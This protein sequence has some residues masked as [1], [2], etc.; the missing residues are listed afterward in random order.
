MLSQPGALDGLGSKLRMVMLL[1]WPAIMA[2]MSNIVM[3]YIDA[4]MVGS[5]GATQS[6]AIGLVATSTWLVW[7]LAAA[8]CTGF[9]VQV[10]HR[11]G[12][13]DD[14]GARSVTRSAI[15][16][17]FLVGLVIAALSVAIAP[18]LPGWL[19]GK[20]DIAGPA[21]W[22]FGIFAAGVPLMGLTFL[23]TALLRSSG[24]MT[25]PGLTN[26]VM[27]L[28]DVVFNFFLIFPTR[29]V[30]VFGADITIPGA[31][32]GVPGAALGTL[33]AYS[34]GGVWMMSYIFNRSTHISHPWQGIKGQARW[35]LRREIPVRAAVIGWPVAL[36]RV[37]MTGAQIF[38][39]T[40]V[41]PLGNAAIAANAFAVTAE[42]LCY[43]PGYGVG[44]AATTLVGQ[45]LGA[46]RK[47]LARGFARIS[48]IS[49]MIIMGVLGLVMWLLAPQ[50]MSLFSSDQEIVSLGSM[51]LRTEAWAEPMFAAAIV[52]YGVFVGAGY[53]VVP[54]CINFG[55]IWLVRITLAWI[56]AP[57]MGLYGIWL[58]MCIELCVR[59][60]VFLICLVGKRWLRKSRAVPAEAPALDASPA[61]EGEGLVM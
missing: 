16:T 39:T 59:G 60:S 56:L 53:T 13:G 44:D 6:A 37:V 48:V 49:G 43:A 52:T 31:G 30:T 4:S 33:L 45:S 40:I 14:E 35:H 51:A 55:S 19:G 3:E 28:M 36:E 2:Q 54:A 22:Y 23:S 41:A 50:M 61:D 17:V 15:I 47:D 32:M 9:A 57:S 26:V 12:A 38:I 46:G 42:S 7:G 11:V 29:D 10:A 20:S 18:A 27:C 5:L 58:A 24:N 8:T 34:A 1:T 25:V 21:S